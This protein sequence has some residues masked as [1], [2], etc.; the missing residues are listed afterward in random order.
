MRELFNDK[1]CLHFISSGYRVSHV[2]SSSYRYT[3]SLTLYHRFYN[4]EYNTHFRS[5]SFFDRITEE[6]S[7]YLFNDF[8]F[9]FIY[10]RKS[11]YFRLNVMITSLYFEQNN[12]KKC[13]IRNNLVFVRRND[14]IIHSRD[15]RRVYPNEARKIRAANLSASSRNSRPLMIQLR[16]HPSVQQLP[17]VSRSHD[18][19][20]EC[21]LV[22]AE[23][24]TSYLARP[25]SE[26]FFFLPSS[27]SIRASFLVVATKMC[28]RAR[29]GQIGRVE[30]N[31]KKDKCGVERS[32]GRSS[33]E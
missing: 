29:E 26:L 25:N 32:A 13:Q 6:N 4:E 24:G 16:S 14:D 12:S 28:M 21:S 33:A 9:Y 20:C 1:H 27:S 7:S 19:T 30:L 5:A 23:Q 18:D 3:V 10:V 8:Q 2:G 15:L 17:K 31:K 11:D 22:A